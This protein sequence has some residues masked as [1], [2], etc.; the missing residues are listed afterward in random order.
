MLKCSGLFQTEPVKFLHFSGSLLGNIIG[1]SQE[2][3]DWKWRDLMFWINY[4]AMKVAVCF[5]FCFSA[6]SS[7]DY[8]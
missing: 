2:Q 4:S 5:G 3:C 1:K 7:A 6:G 8:R